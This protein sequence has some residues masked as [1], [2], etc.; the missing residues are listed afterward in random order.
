MWKVS[1]QDLKGSLVSDVESNMLNLK[2]NNDM[3]VNADMLQRTREV[4]DL[5]GGAAWTS[6]ERCTKDYVGPQ[7]FSRHSSDI[8][9]CRQRRTLVGTMH[10]LPGRGFEEQADGHYH[11]GLSVHQ[12]HAGI[13]WAEI[14][15]AFIRQ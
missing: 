9:G 10:S 14:G 8:T 4:R 15:D 7:H 5:H 13:V 11:D 12:D 2:E 1:L 6:V 3:H